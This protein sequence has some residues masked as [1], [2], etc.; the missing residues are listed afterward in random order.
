MEQVGRTIRVTRLG[1]FSLATNW[2]TGSM[3]LW[4]A[5]ILGFFLV[6]DVIH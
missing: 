6:M 4:I 3:V 5:I 2:P 1:R